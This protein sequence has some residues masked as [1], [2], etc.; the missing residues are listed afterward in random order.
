MLQFPSL[1]QARAWWESQQYR[2][3]KLRQPPV[4]G[5]SAFP[6][7]A[8]AFGNQKKPHH[9]ADPGPKAARRGHAQAER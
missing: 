4:S 7:M 6:S 5:G 3:V 1:E 2:L 8:S 9:I